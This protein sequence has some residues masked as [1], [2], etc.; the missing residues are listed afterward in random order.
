MDTANGKE[1]KRSKKRAKEDNQ[2]EPLEILPPTTE[3]KSAKK[4]KQKKQKKTV[5]QRT[6]ANTQMVLEEMEA[7]G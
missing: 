1:R 4:Q 6:L 2:P 5:D 7:E 3:Q